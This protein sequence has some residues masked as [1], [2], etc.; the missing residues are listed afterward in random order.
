MKSSFALIIHNK[1]LLLLLRD[2]IPT[3]PEP[4]KWTLI[5][6]RV[7]DGETYEEALIREIK[8]ETNISIKLGEAKYLGKVNSKFDED[9]AMYLIYVS[10]KQIQDME[11]GDEGQDVKFFS[12]DEL[13]DISLTKNLEHAKSIPSVYSVLKR[14]LNGDTS[15]KPEELEL[16]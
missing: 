16:V 11:L 3:I 14:V 5:G 7:E 2:N 12:I 6:G 9:I 15:V 4:N 10:D 8:E 13:K 1:K